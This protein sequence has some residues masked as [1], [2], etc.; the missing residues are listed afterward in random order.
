MKSVGTKHLRNMKININH[1]YNHW[2]NCWDILYVFISLAPGI[3]ASNFNRTIFRLFTHKTRLDLR[4]EIALRWIPQYIIND[5]SKLVQVIAWCREATN[6]YLVNFDLDLCRYIVLQ[7]NNEKLI[8]ILNEGVSKMCRIIS[9][10]LRP[11]ANNVCTHRDVRM[12][13][14]YFKLVSI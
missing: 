10:Y 9:L 13:Y 7:D 8:G 5:K 14:I 4:C 1:V 2:N 3:C 6:H 12:Y 11:C